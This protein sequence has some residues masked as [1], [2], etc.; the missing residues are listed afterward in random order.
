MIVSTKGRYA[1]R[2]MLALAEEK[3]GGYV[4]LKEIAAK[5]E[6]SLKY[7]ESILVVL[8]RA[9]FVDAL[10]GRGGG[11]RLSKAPEAYT[12][13]SILQLTE[14]S[15]TSVS[16]PAC[17]DGDCDR[18]GDCKTFPLWRG[19]DRIVSTYLDGI[20]LKDLADPHFFPE[21]H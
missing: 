5:E 3:S 19:L 11:Y 12:V 7:L 20:T 15:M 4:P 14:G 6:I 1:L 16:C 8:S 2:V 9:G 18:A 21:T 10:R 13:G 17:G